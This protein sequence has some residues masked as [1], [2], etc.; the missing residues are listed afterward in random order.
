VAY[1]SAMTMIGRPIPSVEEKLRAAEDAIEAAGQEV[2]PDDKTRDL[3]GQIA[4]I[5]AMSAVPESRAEEMLAQSHRAL[6]YLHPDNLPLRAAATWTLGFAYHL[7]GHRAEASRAYGQALSSSQA[8][9]ST[10]FAI[11]AATSLGR[12]Q[13]SETQ[14]HRAAENYRYVLR[15]SGDPPT[16]G[17]S[18]TYLGLARILYEWN[19]LEA[20]QQ[21]A[22]RGLRLAR[23]LTTVD[24]PAA[25]Q[26]VLARLKLARGDLS[27]AAALLAEADR[28]MRQHKFA[29]R[30]PEIAATQVRTR[31]RQGNLAA[32]LDLAREHDLPIGE[33]RV[34]LAQGETAQALALLEPVCRQAEAKRWQDQ[35]LE[36]KVL[37]SIALSAR[38][39][40]EQS[41]PD[42]ALHLLAETLALAEPGGYLR[43]FVDE[44][45]P[46]AQLLSQAAARGVMPGYVGKLLAAFE[47]EERADRGTVPRPPRPFTQPL[48]EPLS[49]REL[50]VLRLIAEGLSNREIGERLFVSTNT[51]KVHSRSIYGKLGV[52]NR[53]QAAA[54]GRELELLDPG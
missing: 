22:Q 18:A 35:R 21:H 31:L 28:F 14:L 47:A 41:A 13:E 25:C 2:E 17:A 46:M 11:A 12:V 7:Q 50:D 53:T 36:A 49:E 5:R 16:P 45:P 33:A 26:V 19:E 42:E 4:A 48:I 34:R 30:M 40:Q 9:G 24:T 23:Q 6:A 37:Q 29:H 54:R 8:S 44:G 20:A 32:A 51:V 1:A 43:T 39:R 10:M 15:L 52:H 38:A 27:G 3:I